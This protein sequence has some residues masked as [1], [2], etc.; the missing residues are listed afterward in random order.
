[1]QVAPQ[2]ERM[3][4]LMQAHRNISF[5]LNNL[6]ES[7]FDYALERV[8]LEQQLFELD[9]QIDWDSSAYYAA[10]AIA[11]QNEHDYP[12]Y[13]ARVI[14]E[15][16]IAAQWQLDREVADAAAAAAAALEHEAE[17][18]RAIARCKYEVRGAAYML[19]VRTLKDPAKKLKAVKAAL[20]CFVEWRKISPWS[21][22]VKTLV[23]EAQ[24][25]FAATQ[26]ALDL[27]AEYV[28]V[29]EPDVEEDWVLV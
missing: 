28:F 13:H 21:I 3:F 25:I 16:A 9:A 24:E 27:E 26:E 5:T 4:E 22:E 10:E 12:I 20:S 19:C 7:R 6:D 2:T 11:H 8:Y 17:A 29:Q 14:R 23:K 1:M 15:A 18:Q